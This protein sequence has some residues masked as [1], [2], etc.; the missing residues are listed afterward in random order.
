MSP[1]TEAP[2]R[3]RGDWTL[4]AY[5]GD[6]EHD[7]DG[8]VL[9]P[10]V[11]E[12]VHTNLITT[13]GKALTLDRLFG[14]SGAAPLAYTGV[15]TGS[16]A[17]A[18]GDTALTGGVWKLFDATPTR[19]GLT[20]TST[21][22]YGTTEANITIAEAALGTTSAGGVILNRLAPIGPFAKST[23]VSLALTVAITQA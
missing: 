14:L 21:T 22:T 2:L 19:S 4:T 3:L 23:A 1:F 17:A 20:V 18:V 8:R 13:V 6:V 10:V 12:A 16:T 5:E 9:N 7:Q 15:G 11:F